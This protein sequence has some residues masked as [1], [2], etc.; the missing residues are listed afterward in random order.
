M[1]TGINEFKILTKHVSC[2]CKC[3]FDGRKCTSNQKW[4]NDKCQCECKKHICEKDYIWN[5]S[6]SSSKNYKYLT[7]IIDI[8]L[9]T[10]DEFIEEET[11]CHKHVKN[12]KPKKLCINNIL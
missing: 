7:S 10:C 2:T 3:K 5:P 9:I 8:S 12:N 11:I 1:I 4:K 6:T